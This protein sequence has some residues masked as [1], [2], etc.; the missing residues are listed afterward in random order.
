MNIRISESDFFVKTL[1]GQYI[2]DTVF[3]FG[4]NTAVPILDQAFQKGVHQAQRNIEMLCQVALTQSGIFLNCFEDFQGSNVLVIHQQ[5]IPGVA[6]AP[7]GGLHVKIRNRIV[8]AA[9]MVPMVWHRK[10]QDLFRNVQKMNTSG[11][12]CQSKNK[13]G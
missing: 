4:A 10:V 9:W 6:T 13:F 1:P 11:N 7:L 5:F 3:R 8:T 12:K 2:R